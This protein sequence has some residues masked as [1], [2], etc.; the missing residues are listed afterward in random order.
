MV[1]QV[2]LCECSA[3]VLRVVLSGTACDGTLI[4]R[5]RFLDFVVLC[6]SRH[7]TNVYYYS[8]RTLLSTS[9]SIVLH[10]PRR[11]S[12]AAERA[13]EG[14]H[15]ILVRGPLSVRILSTARASEA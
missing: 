15:L 10:H 2:L 4:L 8:W 13:R 12:Q 9:L 6:Y 1:M 5:Q 7:E 14:N 11:T 3:D